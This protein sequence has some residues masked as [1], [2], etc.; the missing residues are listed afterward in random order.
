M[1]NNA[2]S[3]RNPTIQLSREEVESSLKN[4]DQ[5]MG[6]MEVSP[7]TIYDRPAG[8]EVANIPTESILSE[9]GLGNGRII[10][11]INNEAITSPDQISAF[12][13]GMKQGG[14]FTI[15]V[16]NRGV[17]RRTQIIRLEIK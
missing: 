7:V 4:I 16:S 10:T 17:R 6:Q 13:Q 8:I 1:K 3:A 5:L 14:D 12:L 15:T 9:L 2:E 11:S